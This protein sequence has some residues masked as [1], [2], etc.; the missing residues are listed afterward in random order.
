MADLD[1]STVYTA[2]IGGTWA[3][4]TIPAITP[5]NYQSAQAAAISALDTIIGIT[6]STV[7]FYVVYT[8]AP[9]A[10]VY[11]TRWRVE[12]DASGP[13]MLLDTTIE[14]DSDITLLVRLYS[15]AEVRQV[16]ADE[17]LHDM[18]YRGVYSP[19]LGALMLR[20]AWGTGARDVT[21][22]GFGTG[23]FT[24]ETLKFRDTWNSI[25]YEIPY[26]TPAAQI[27]AYEITTSPNAAPP[28]MWLVSA[29]DLT[30]GWQVSY[31]VSTPGQPIAD[32]WDTSIQPVP[33]FDPLPW[34]SDTVS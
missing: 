20:R 22:T 31:C 14:H 21:L 5:D 32:R 11:R 34:P 26:D 4:G 8:P 24:P 30:Q 23:T 1:N 13:G 7:E 9:G 25:S 27:G 15:Y 17:D 33:E 10:P 29:D 28:A 19:L 18:P 3:P 16:V 2:S 12:A 6:N